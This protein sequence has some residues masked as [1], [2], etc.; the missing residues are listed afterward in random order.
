NNLSGEIPSS[1]SSLR[2]LSY[3]DLGWNNLNGPISALFGNLTEVI[4]IFLD[5]NNFTGQIPSSLL[6]LKDLNVIDL[7]YNKF[8]GSI[9]MSLGNLTK[10]TN[11]MLQH[12]NFT[13]YIPSSLSHLKDLNLVDLSYNKFEGSIPVSFGNL[14]KVTTIMLQYNNFTSHIPSSLSNL[15]DLTFIDFSHNNFGGFGG[16]I[17]FLTN[18]TKLIEVDLSYNQLTSQMC[19]FQPNNSLQYLRV[20]NNRLY[21]S[22]PNSIS[23]LVNL[24][25]INLS[26][27][28]LSGIVELDKSTNLA[29]L[30]TLDVSNNSRL[31]G[32]KS[33]SNYTFLQKLDLSSC[34]ITEFPNFLKSSKLLKKLELSNNRISSQI[35]EWTFEVLE[36]L[37]FLD[38]HANRLSGEI[39]SM[40]CNASYLE[41]LDISNNN[42]SGKG[43]RAYQPKTQAKKKLMPRGLILCYGLMCAL[44][45]C[46]K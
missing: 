39:P 30:E 32:I 9:L 38:L 10:V 40:I 26:S 41:I 3:L 11:I 12:N 43:D 36:N 29:E 7:S 17:S 34:N 5:N 13:G 22:I 31:L 37:L 23:N 21:G 27:N 45:Y 14:T 8:Q 19:E 46:W 16:K 42:L 44:R 35:P 1:F 24:I 4:Q 28:D 18:L 25:E 33:N 15:K 20:E 2:A 6:S